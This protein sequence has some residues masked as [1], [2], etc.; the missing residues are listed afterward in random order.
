MKFVKEYQC[1]S[2]TPSDEE[3]NECLD[4]AEKEDCIVKLRWYF[5]Y[6]GWYERYIKKGM[7][8]EEC[9]NSLPKRYGV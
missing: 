2:R 4:I 5:P 3:I 1:D 7:T 8:F 6:S 9:K